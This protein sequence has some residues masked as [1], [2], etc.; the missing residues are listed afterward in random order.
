MTDDPR[1]VEC[2][3]ERCPI[4]DGG[5]KSYA[6]PHLCLGPWMILQGNPVRLVACQFPSEA[7]AQLW[8]R[9]DEILH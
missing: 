6:G 7:A 9:G 5:F 8:I 2:G 4:R 1:I 3:C